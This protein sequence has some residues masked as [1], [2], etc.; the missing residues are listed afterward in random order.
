MEQE[1]FYP[2]TLPGAPFQLEDGEELQND[3]FSPF[4]ALGV[5]RDA[6]EEGVEKE[7][8]GICKSNQAETDPW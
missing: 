5:A 7:K 2:V 4:E 3:G 6:P 8:M 1:L